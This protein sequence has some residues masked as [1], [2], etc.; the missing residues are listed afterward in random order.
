[1]DDYEAVCMNCHPM[2]IMPINIFNAN[3][4]KCIICK[5]FDCLLMGKPIIREPK[6]NLRFW[7]KSK[8]V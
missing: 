1:M 7:S 4:Y 6:I 8:Y 3:G 2:T 5:S